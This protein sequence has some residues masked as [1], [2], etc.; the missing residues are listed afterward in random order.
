MIRKPL[1]PV[2]SPPGESGSPARLPLPGAVGRKRLW[3]G[4][5]G[6]I[7]IFHLFAL[8]AFVPWLFSWTGLM[9]MIVS[10]LFFGNIGLVLCYHRLLSHRS[11]KVP[12]WLERFFVCVA[13]CCWQDTPARWVTNHRY[14]HIYADEQDDPHSPLVAFLWA[15]VGWLLFANPSTRSVGAYQKYGRDVLEDPFYM[16]LEKTWLWIYIY[17]IHVSLYLI[18][19]AVAGWLIGATPM[20]ALQMAL[21][22]LVWAVIVRTVIVWHMTWSVNSFTHLLG[23]RNYETGE[24][25]RNNWAVAMITGGD[26]WHNNH[27]YDPAS[28]SVQHR[29]WE[30]DPVYYLIKL[31]KWV[32]L[33]TDVVRTKHVRDVERAERARQIAPL[34][35]HL[36]DQSRRV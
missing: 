34:A 2:L 21:S 5:A 18:A 19:G 22:L 13:L 9:A 1:P 3:V 10:V 16:R 12:R 17:A 8:S 6:S 27:H 7:A 4:Y 25:S 31:L 30:L 33:A 15:H 20:A 26:G 24:N 36:E 23:Y 35:T 29:W 11:F 32:G 14:H 28:A